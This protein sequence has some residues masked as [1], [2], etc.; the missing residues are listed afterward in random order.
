MSDK[1]VNN[2]NNYQDIYFANDTF[3]FSLFFLLLVKET[4]LNKSMEL[5]G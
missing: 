1:W 5:M 2:F 4:Q 3:F